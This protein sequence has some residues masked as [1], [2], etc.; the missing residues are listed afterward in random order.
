MIISRIIIIF[1]FKLYPIL[2]K[3][4]YNTF[5]RKIKHFLRKY[6][7]I[8][9]C[10][11]VFSSFLICIR[12]TITYAKQVMEECI[13]QITTL[14]QPCRDLR[15][16]FT[17]RLTVWRSH[18]ISLEQRHSEKKIIL[19]EFYDVIQVF[20]VMPI[21]QSEVKAILTSIYLMLI[22]YV[23][24]CKFLFIFLSFTIQFWIKLQGTYFFIR[25]S[26]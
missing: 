20:Y 16:S 7:I 17:K 12:E 9:S 14:L 5:I 24:L 8:R 10:T 18:Y 26:C 6:H 4:L 19:L 23:T 25:N 13:F 15:S 11:N 22:P 1:V 2:F 21:V 3:L